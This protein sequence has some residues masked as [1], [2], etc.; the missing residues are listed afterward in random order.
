MGWL[1]HDYYDK[2]TRM[3]EHKWWAIWLPEIVL[4]SAL[5]GQIIFWFYV[6]IRYN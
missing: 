2:Q 4:V 5:L 3:W 1:D 6:S